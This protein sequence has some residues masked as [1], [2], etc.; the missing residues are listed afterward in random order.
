VYTERCLGPGDRDVDE[1]GEGEE[2]GGAGLAELQVGT[3]A[4]RP[5]FFNL[6]SER[7]L[8]ELGDDVTSDGV[9]VLERA[10]SREGGCAGRGGLGSLVHVN[11][12]SEW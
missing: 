1:R 5:V 3:P 7:Q 9:C 6:D 2:A 4:G 12:I 11:L 8:R 10:G